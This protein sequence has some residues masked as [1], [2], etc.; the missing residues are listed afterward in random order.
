[1]IL[2][3]TT[4]RGLFALALVPAACRADDW[5]CFR[6]D[7]RRSAATS[8]ALSFPL[9]AAWAYRGAAPRPAWPEPGRTVNW[10][11]FDYACQPVSAGGVVVFG[12]SA[13]DTVYALGENDGRIIW[14]FTAD[15][16]VRFA[17][18]LAGG[19]CY[20]ASD[21][22]VVYCLDAKTGAL[23][24]SH[25]SYQGNRMISGNGRMISRWPCRSGVMVI[26][27]TVYATAGMWPSEGTSFFALDRHTGKVRW[28]NDT[29]GSDYLMYPH[30]GV[31][32]GGPTPQGD[33][34]S[35]GK[36]LLVPTGQSAPAGFDLQ[37]GKLRYWDASAP[38][39]TVAAL[40]DDC[41]MVAGRAWQGDQETRLGEA[42]LWISDGITFYDLEAGNR[43]YPPKWRKY[44]SLP[45]SARGGMSRLRGMIEPVG[46]RDRMV[47]AN[48]TLYTS[49]MGA[50]DAID[51][52]GSEL[53]VVWRQPA[54][55][56][57]SL[58]L[59]GAHLLAG[60]DGEIRAVETATGKTVWSS[61]VPGQV[62]G[63]AVANGRLIVSTDR[64]GIHVFAARSGKP[65]VAS[66][67][68]PGPLPVP[69]LPAGLVLE[70]G[71]K[72]FGLVCGTTDTTLAE[73]LAAAGNLNVICLLDDAAGVTRARQRLLVHGYGTRVVV[74]QT[75]PGGKL[76]Y[77]DFF[78]NV[79]IIAGQT[80]R[81]EPAELYRVLQPCTGRMYFPGAAAGGMAASLEV[82]GIPATELVTTTGVPCVVRG[83]LEGAFDWNSK[84]QADQ[85]LKWPL[86]LLW[87]GGPGRDRMLHRHGRTYPPPIP[88]NGRIFAEG[89]SHVIAVDAYNGTELWAWYAPGFR[90]IYADDK[91]AYIGSG[92][93]LQCDARTGEIVKVYGDPQPFVFGLDEP[94]VFEAKKGNKY[95]GRITVAKVSGALE[96]LLEC[97]TP[98][99]HNA[100]CWMLDFDFREPARRLRPAARGAFSVIVN[101]TSGT[102][103]KYAQ[104][105]GVVVPP[106]TLTRARPDKGPVTLRLPLAEVP[107]MVGRE[108]EN[109]DL[110]AEILLYE[111]GKETPRRWL[112]EMPLTGKPG[113]LATGPGA[114]D[115]LQN[116]TAT[117]VIS[118][119]KSANVSPVGLVPKA[120]RRAAPTGSDNW[121][122]L[123]YFVRHD[124]N[125]P[126]P[127]AAPD[128]N[129]SLGERTDPFSGLTAQQK[130]QRGY[131][132]SGTISSLTMD[133]FRSGT[134][135]MYD[136]E[137][138]SGMRNFPG[139]KPGCGVSLLPALGV[140]FSVEANADC[141]CPYNFSTSLALAPAATRKQE[142]WALFY[143]TPKNASV[144]KIALN[145]GAPGDRRDDDRKLWLGYPRAPLM[146]D[147]AGAEKRPHTFGMPL[148]M[149][150][151]DGG[152][153][154][155]I[156]ADRTLV[157]GGNPW[158]YASQMRGIES[159]N[160]GLI[161]YDPKK[162]CLAFPWSGPLKPDGRLTESGWAD[163]N[164]V[165]VRT[166]GDKNALPNAR[167]RVRFDADNLY[168]GYEEEPAAGRGK[169]A[170]WR[171][172]V[173]KD[174][175]DIWSGDHVSVILKD[176]KHSPCAQF[177]VSA[178]G[179]RTST[180]ASWRL[181]I[182]QA[183]GLTI[184]GNASDWAGKG[185]TF[186]L[187][188]NRGEVRVAW[189][190]QGLAVLT[191]TP[192]DFFSV[193][194]DWNALRTQVV[195]AGDRTIL[196]T[197]IQPAEGTAEAM[198]PTLGT[199][200]SGSVDMDDWKTFRAAKKLEM[201][202]ASAR[203]GE[204]FV[205]ESLFPWDALGL[206]PAAGA[207]CGL[208]L[209]VFNPQ[210]GD[211]NIAFGG[212][213][214][215]DI[216]RGEMLPE[217]E[218]ATDTRPASIKPPT[219]RR[220]FYGSTL[221]YDLPA[222][223]IP[224]ARWSAA[225]TAD[226]DAFRAELVIPRPLLTE[227]GLRL[228][229][230][231]IAVRPPARAQPSFASLSSLMA[232]R[233]HLTLAAAAKDRRTFTVRLHF[234]ELDEV[235]PGERVFGVRL[236][237]CTVEEALDVVKAA[238]G[239]RKGLVRTYQGVP[240]T[241]NLTLEFVPRDPAPSTC[242][243]P[244]LSGLEIECE[245]S[246]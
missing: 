92:S 212:G 168:L 126:R 82:A 170:A 171:R 239:L 202:L 43:K 201:P 125:V 62:R 74:H 105:A 90:S 21:D 129:P 190:P 68:P 242:G 216:I 70:P 234:A 95:S 27:D 124:G 35:D 6:K 31:S 69:K 149:K 123:P 9:T 186:P 184:D 23:V 24:W 108:V 61:P 211:Q 246:E 145:L 172:N 192:R 80:G 17:P 46:G 179:A 50:L 113:F 153:A 131:G 53:K 152:T 155:R 115:L 104:P 59:A 166:G 158:I 218:L 78:A 32:Y 226:D 127:P 25:R 133:F 181:P 30:E 45:G 58:A 164:G 154:F 176:R 233:Y 85:R 229:D 214:R 107:A 33:L 209:V 88:A 87:F 1:M 140:L 143:A 77:A 51:A 100:D 22:G 185:V 112:R 65:P 195:G 3:K 220:D 240:A 228:E 148:A 28:C 12:S 244:I 197:V 64:G 193:Q 38:G 44:D 20:F 200:T 29:C 223:E 101:M 79:V 54:P 230:L 183:G 162:D 235:K 156:N 4:L 137:D 75:P 91:Y 241:T 119:D 89:E 194:K 146:E 205:V 180:D 93:I 215:R 39:S 72:G 157:D 76:P 5:P 83:P 188:E 210:A 110:R 98:T 103:R 81:I 116:G 221:L 167:L 57:Y 96:L 26:G 219:T 217:L 182:P 2:E 13:E 151:S 174:Q 245:Q 18:H 67:P 8:E 231:D 177:G 144:R 199:D 11:D 106:M 232:R 14:K 73:A 47:Y 128:I 243:M 227:L 42:D 187:P 175:A 37:T 147:I 136:L 111:A 206:K 19:M 102:L 142:D 238:G 237:G 130:Y 15:A 36:T 117:F 159:L 66:S 118:G 84:Y 198:R 138:D 48:H 134:L 173:T 34:L 178:G 224:V 71:L 120:D 114:R 121:G 225:A 165:A 141:F 63:I 191:I 139:M 204:N 60:L 163:D 135:G 56:V 55:R 16:P 160:L 40:G 203:D 86:E 7:E 99:P 189:T 10:F 222:R 236:Q 97:D 161:Y 208:K 122:K 109:F 207:C 41:V 169:P 150:L 196:E 52:S 94:Q 213:A 49:G 132:C